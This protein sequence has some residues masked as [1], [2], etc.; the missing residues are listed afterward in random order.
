MTSKV[1]TPGDYSERPSGPRRVERTQPRASIPEVP[2]TVSSIFLDPQ[3]RRPDG[4]RVHVVNTIGD[5]PGA[6]TTALAER[7]DPT[8]AGLPGDIVR[9]H[10]AVEGGDR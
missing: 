7:R 8:G 4:E 5:R 1:T 6:E 2:G 9:Q 10:L 3:R